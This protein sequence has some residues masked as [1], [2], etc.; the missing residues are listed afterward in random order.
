MKVIFL[1]IDGVMNSHVFYEK[2]HKSLKN[3]IGRK[4]NRIKSNFKIFFLGKD[5]YKR[6]GYKDVDSF[7]TYEHQIKRLIEETCPVKWIWLSKFCNEH[8]IKICISS[9]WRNHF[10]DRSSRIPEWW[11]RALVDLGFKKGTFVGITTTREKIRGNEIDTWLRYRKEVTDYAILDDDSDMMPHQFKKFHHCDP[12][13]GL[14]PNH[15]YRINRQFNG[16]STYENLSE[17]IK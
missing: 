4:L 11:E 1:D 8:D 9:T 13:F 10:G 15:L 17:T 14:S 2:R 12:W 16:E 3:V 6:K 5:Y 7:F